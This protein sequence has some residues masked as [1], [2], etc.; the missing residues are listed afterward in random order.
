MSVKLFCRLAVLFASINNAFKISNTHSLNHPINSNVNTKNFEYGGSTVITSDFLR[1]TTLSKGTLGWL[2]AP[3]PLHSDVVEVQLEIRISGPNKFHGG[4]GIAM[5][6]F[7]AEDNSSSFRSHYQK[8]DLFG[9]DPSRKGFSV[10]LKT[11]E[12]NY[13]Q[14]IYVDDNMEQDRED[15]SKKENK[16]SKR[17]SSCAV[18]IRNQDNLKLIVRLFRDNVYVYK[19]IKRPGHKRGNT[20]FC[21]DA[22]LSRKFDHKPVLG[23]SA[24]TSEKTD[25]IDVYSLQVRYKE[26]SRAQGTENVEKFLERAR[27]NFPR[28]ALR[29]PK[30]RIKRM[31]WF[32]AVISGMLLFLETVWEL[33]LLQHVVNDK[34]VPK[35]TLNLINLAVPY[36]NYV[37]IGLFVYTL[38]SFRILMAIFLAPIFAFKVY[39]LTNKKNKLKS[40]EFDYTKNFNGYSIMQCASVVAYAF[41]VM[42]AVGKL[43]SF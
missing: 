2:K 27:K 32:A 10:V 36:T 14:I 3:K 35:E 13:N 23:V 18:N 39:R 21:L 20:E 9:V 12:K 30:N 28:K 17:R 37:M 40:D 24:T 8:K 26:P 11:N 4:D 1:L 31:F 43:V 25:N 34:L 15:N 7:D 6:F 41:Y 19:V 22:H 5:H 16:K 29:L 38:L 42:L 33:S